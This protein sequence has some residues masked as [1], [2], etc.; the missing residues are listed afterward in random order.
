MELPQIIHVR[1]GS[2]NVMLSSLPVAVCVLR[3]L[4]LLLE[5]RNKRRLLRKQYH[6]LSTEACAGVI[7]RLSLWWINPILAIGNARL[8]TFDDLPALEGDL[9]S[10]SLRAKLQQAWD[11][12]GMSNTIRFILPFRIG[13]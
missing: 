4:L 8:L 12:T 3:I 10:G 7:N 6:H 13:N 2:G 5:S 11:G 1:F 9:S